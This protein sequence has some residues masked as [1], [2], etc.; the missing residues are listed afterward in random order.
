MM[1]LIFGSKVSPDLFAAVDR[2]SSYSRVP[3]Q[4]DRQKSPTRAVLGRKS[5]PSR[6]QVGAKS[7]PSRFQIE[8][9]SEAFRRQRI[10]NGK[11]ANFSPH[12]GG[13]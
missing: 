11:C 8:D 4:L 2:S 1:P 7:V 13:K 9:L 10:D 3:A 6:C 12:L 5:V